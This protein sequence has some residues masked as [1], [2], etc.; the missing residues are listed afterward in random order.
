MTTGGEDLGVV[1][2]ISKLAEISSTGVAAAEAFSSTSRE[3]ATEEIYWTLSFLN[4]P[5]RA[6]ILL[7][8]SGSFPRPALGRSAKCLAGEHG[9][10]CFKRT[11]LWE[12]GISMQDAWPAFLCHLTPTSDDA[13]I[14]LN[15]EYMQV[16]QKCF[17]TIHWKAHEWVCLRSFKLWP[18]LV[19]YYRAILCATWISTP[20]GLSVSSQ[21]STSSS[22]Y[23]RWCLFLQHPEY[24]L[25]VHTYLLLFAISLSIPQ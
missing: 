7:S 4:P 18:Q 24:F 13:P 19:A 20:N 2:L 9:N 12:L 25:N 17:Q 5:L 14:H 1:L 15:D 23:R 8:T 11:A 21:H 3:T 16:L 6:R 22:A 10:Y